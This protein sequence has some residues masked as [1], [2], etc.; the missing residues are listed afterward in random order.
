MVPRFV[1]LPILALILVA[2]S[3]S[4]DFTTGSTGA[5]GVFH[6]TSNTVVDLSQADHGPGT[7]T[8]DPA[9]WAVVFNYTT[10]DVPAG[11]TVTFTNHKSGAPVVWL[12]Q[13]DVALSGS[14]V[15]DG[16]GGGGYYNEA[17]FFAQPGPGGFEGGRREI[18]ATTSRACAGLGPGGGLTVL[19]NY[20][21]GGAYATSGS[22]GAGAAGGAPY[23]DERILPLIGGS[24]GAAGN[25]P[26]PYGF[27]FGGGAGGGAILVASPTGILLDGMITAN[28]G[29]GGGGVGG[30]GSGGAIRLRAPSVTGLGLLRAYGG[31]GSSDTTYGLGRIRIE[32][33]NLSVADVGIPVIVGSSTP[34]PIFPDPSAPTLEVTLI[35]TTAV[36]SDPDA[37]IE[38]IDAVVGDIGLVTLHI[39]ATNIPEGT[40]VDVILVPDGGNRITWQ[41]T[42]LTGSFA[43]SSATATFPMDRIRR[44]EMI[45]RATTPAGPVSRSMPE[46]GAR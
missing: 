12:A 28:G 6:P 38:T 1:V 42:P 37:G 5:D 25:V 39:Q 9:H 33:S 23:G 20:G 24:G 27:P 45:L 4:A 21:G 26:P 43:S 41:S 3:A 36:P 11:V 22:P 19:G 44:T 17:P 32:A 40:V 14:I 35:D 10:I 13:G 15:L 16:A 8:Y 2:S 46:A 18:D 30:P 7:G 29:P 31:S 34:G